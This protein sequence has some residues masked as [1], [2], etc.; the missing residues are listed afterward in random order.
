MPSFDAT[1]PWGRGPGT[2]WGRGSCGA[3]LRRQRGRSRAFGRSAGRQVPVMRPWSR[4][5]WGYGPWWFGFYGPKGAA[6]SASPQDEAAALR[7]EEA[8]LKGELEAIQKRLA[9]LGTSQT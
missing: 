9:E 4:P 1:G 5:F 2:G 6:A 8:S 3:G 7:K